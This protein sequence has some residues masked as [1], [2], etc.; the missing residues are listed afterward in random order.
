[1]SRIVE[2]NENERDP[3]C[4]EHR[5]QADDQSHQDGGWDEVAKSLCSEEAWES[6]TFH[7]LENVILSSIEEFRIIS[8]LFFNTNSDLMG[9]GVGELDFALGT[10]K[11]VGVEDLFS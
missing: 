8:T 10:R 11:E 1:M 7:R 2:E 3:E 6:V 5:E 9:Y 4:S